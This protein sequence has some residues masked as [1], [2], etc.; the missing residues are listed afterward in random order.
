MITGAHTMFY[1]DD[2]ATLRAFLRDKLRLPCFD[3][4]GGWLIFDFQQSD[5]GCHPTDFAGSPPS[6]THHIS[7]LCD[8]IVKTVAEL[9]SRGVTFTRGIVDEGYA[10]AT[11]FAMPGGM[12]VQLYEPRYRPAAKSAATKRRTPATKTKAKMGKGRGKTATTAKRRPRAK[13]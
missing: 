6:G 10:L 5:M 9:T 2:A 3:A 11:S 12:T 1:S 7:F 4:G 13:R 8:D